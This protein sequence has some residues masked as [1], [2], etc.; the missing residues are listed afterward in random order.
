MGMAWT[1][2]LASRQQKISNTPFSVLAWLSRMTCSPKIMVWRHSTF[3][4][5]VLTSTAMKVTTLARSFIVIKQT[6]SFSLKRKRNEPVTGS[7]HP[8]SKSVSRLHCRKRVSCFL[9]TLMPSMLTSEM[10]PCTAMS[11]S[12]GYVE[13]YTSRAWIM[14]T[15]PKAWVFPTRLLTPGL[16]R[17]QTTTL[18]NPAGPLLK[19]R[20]AP[21]QHTLAFI[22]WKSASTDPHLD[23]RLGLIFT[24]IFYLTVSG[25]LWYIQK[26]WFFTWYDCMLWHIRSYSSEILD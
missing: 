13:S 1:S 16:Q 3:L 19:R 2:K 22:E 14:W 24:C 18:P 11:I 6:K 12:Y 5:W 7:L 23:I 26:S 25:W 15:K 17:K 10:N 21:K 4:E 8:I 20:S 9:R